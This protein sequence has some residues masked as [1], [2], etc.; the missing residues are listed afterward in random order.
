MSHASYTYRMTRAFLLHLISKGSKW[1]K[2]NTFYLLICSRE[3]CNP[4]KNLQIVSRKN[5]TT[6]T[7]FYLNTCTGGVCKIVTSTKIVS[8]NSTIN[9][10]NKSLSKTDVEL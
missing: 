9:L 2:V 10:N 6:E 7:Y 8:A 4:V 1:V 3:V 5:K